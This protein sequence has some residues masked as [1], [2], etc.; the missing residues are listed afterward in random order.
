MTLTLNRTP[1][2]PAV[3]AVTYG[4][5]VL[6]GGYGG[7]ESMPMPRL[8]PESVTRLPGQRLRFQAIADGRA[9]GLIPVA[10]MHHEH[11]NVYW[12]T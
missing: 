6:S 4:P 9:V 12:L 10:R 1:D 11:Y 2:Q 3:Q 5:V 8:S 7:V